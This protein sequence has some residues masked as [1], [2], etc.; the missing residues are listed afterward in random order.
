MKVNE[1]VSINIENGNGRLPKVFESYQ[2]VTGYSFPPGEREEPTYYLEN[3]KVIDIA[4]TVI[5]MVGV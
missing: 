4:T 3:T 2:Q 1:S 5:F